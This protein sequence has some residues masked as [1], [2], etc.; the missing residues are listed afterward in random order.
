MDLINK[1][2]K[3]LFKTGISVEGIVQ[4]WEPNNYLI[5]SLDNKSIFIIQNPSEDT[6]A[7]VVS[8]EDFIKP[9]INLKES[10]ILD[11]QLA[12][13]D[14][15]IY[16][17]NLRTKKLAELYKESIMQERE[18]VANKFKSH[19]IGENKQVEYGLPGFF[20]KQGSK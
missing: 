1:K 10:S 2:I 8:L 7:I 11:V 6:L 20:K 5:K 4:S 18:I 12:E 19:S 3:I 16:D 17:P 15:K 14:N 13:E 9:E